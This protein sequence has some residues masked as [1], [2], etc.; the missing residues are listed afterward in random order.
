MHSE[1]KIG[2]TIRVDPLNVR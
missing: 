1:N 2:S